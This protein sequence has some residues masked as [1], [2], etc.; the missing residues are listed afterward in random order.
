MAAE[1][2]ISSYL[3]LAPD[4]LNG[5]K[6]LSNEEF[7][8]QMTDVEIEA[9]YNMEPFE[10]L[11]EG[12]TEDI[13]LRPDLMPTRKPLYTPRTSRQRFITRPGTHDLT[14]MPHKH[15]RGEEV[16]AAARKHERA[17]NLIQPGWIRRIPVIDLDED[18]SGET[19]SI[20]VYRVDAPLS[21]LIVVKEAGSLTDG[22][23]FG[24]NGRL[25]TTI[26]ELLEVQRRQKQ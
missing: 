24:D 26:R 11:S 10:P 20:P 6:P 7:L 5:N 9:M 3:D 22:M 13:H 1:V 8:V 25:I 14:K 19:T 2:P 23:S 4:N 16:I 17:Q 12:R 15:T 18:N 21:R